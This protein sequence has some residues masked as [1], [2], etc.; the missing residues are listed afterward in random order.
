MVNTRFWSD[1]YVCDLDPTEKYLFLYFLTCSLTSICGIYEIPI[2]NIAFET[3]IDKE[4]VEKILKRFERDGRMIYRNGW[5]A[6]KHFARHQMLNPKIVAGIRYELEKVP[7]DLAEYIDFEFKEKKVKPMRQKLTPKKRKL[8]LEKEGYKC[9]FCSSTKDLEID[10]IVPVIAGGK[11]VEENLQV[12]CS[13]CNGKKNAELRWNRNGDVI[14]IPPTKMG[15]LSD[16][17]SNSNL[18]LNS[19]LNNAAEMNSAG[20]AEVIKLFEEVNPNASEW[21]RNKTQRAAVK[22]LL[23]KVGRE[24]LERLVKKLPQIT[25]QKFA[26][27][28]TSP[29]ELKRDWAKLGLFLKQEGK[30]TASGRGIA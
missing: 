8:I 26:P 4:M 3:G 28:I 19:N 7:K 6:I 10:H 15:G 21:Y 13:K 29:H 9:R 16:S 14:Y 12:L 5:I 22:W 18:N 25:S 11:S 30:L 20:I 2:R 24:P 27:K 1:S 17:N 23:E